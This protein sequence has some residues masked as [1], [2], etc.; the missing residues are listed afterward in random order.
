MSRIKEA[1]VFSAA[2]LDR[3]AANLRKL[4]LPD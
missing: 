4:G 3:M 1:M 2:V